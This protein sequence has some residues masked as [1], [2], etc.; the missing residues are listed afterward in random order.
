MLVVVSVS[1]CLSVVASFESK[2]RTPVV[3]SEFRQLCRVV[4]FELF[5]EPKQ[6]CKKKINGLS[7]NITTARYSLVVRDICIYCVFA[8]SVLCV[9]VEDMAYL[10][11]DVVGAD[12]G[13]GDWMSAG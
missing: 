7:K 5:D 9:Q 13:S 6:A 8:C 11:F 12:D 3:L 1:V 4:K 10:E 2:S